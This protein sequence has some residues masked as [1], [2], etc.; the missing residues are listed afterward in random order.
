MTFK[1]YKN[2]FPKSYI[3]STPFV[4]VGYTANITFNK[5]ACLENKLFDYNFFLLMYD[6]ETNRIGI[7]FQKEET[8]FS[9][10]INEGSN[11]TIGAYRFLKYY[12]IKPEKTRRYRFTFENNT[13]IIDLN[14]P[15]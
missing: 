7:K 12:N 14:K 4:S 2:Q 8:D 15:F 6:K 10:K 3:N 5:A 11:V 13:A 1:V 9:R